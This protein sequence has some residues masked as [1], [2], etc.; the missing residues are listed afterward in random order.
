MWGILK[1]NLNEGGGQVLLDDRK[2]GSLNIISGHGP[3]SV[4]RGG[5]VIIVSVRQHEEGESFQN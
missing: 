3:E 2:V 5:E 1:E 4:R